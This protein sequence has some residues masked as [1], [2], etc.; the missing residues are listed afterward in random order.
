MLRMRFMPSDFHPILL[1][2]G[3]KNDLAVFAD[4]LDV[5]SETGE[6]TTLERHGVSSADTSVQLIEQ[7][8]HKPGLWQ[9]LPGGADLVWHLSRDMAA[10]FAQEIADLAEG[11]AMAGSATL[12]CEV[13]NEIRVVVSLGEFEDEF[14]IGNAC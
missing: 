14:L 11:K 1:V 4:V 6:T 5:F 13:L 3:D 12:E 8:D 10:K 2:L 9:S 7:G